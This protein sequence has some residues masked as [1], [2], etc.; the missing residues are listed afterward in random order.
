MLKLTEVSHDFTF[1]NIIDEVTPVPSL[2]RDFS[3]PVRLIV[4]QSDEDLSL[5]MAYDTDSFNKWE[6]GHNS[7]ST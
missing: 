4:D 7:L 5:L 3:A 1:D 6:A 2:L